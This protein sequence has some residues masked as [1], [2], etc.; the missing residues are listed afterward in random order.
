MLGVSVLGEVWCLV[1]QVSLF[2]DLGFVR[3]FYWCSVK[4]A[5]IFMN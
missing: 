5:N 4:G 1:E 3:G 2:N